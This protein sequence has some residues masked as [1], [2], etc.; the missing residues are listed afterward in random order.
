MKIILVILLL[1][2]GI[3]IGYG[4]QIEQQKSIVPEIRYVLNQARIDRDQQHINYLVDLVEEHE[5]DL[6]ELNK[7]LARQQEE[8]SILS[9]KV[10]LYEAMT[11]Q[12][13]EVEAIKKVTE[14]GE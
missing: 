8:I 4:W 14:K 13:I 2:G 1:L 6:N 5:R 11:G 7:Q 10:A 9:I 12:S 3:S